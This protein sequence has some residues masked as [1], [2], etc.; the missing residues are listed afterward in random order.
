MIFK[1]VGQRVRKFMLVLSVSVGLAAMLLVGCG[2]T[3][4][5]SNRDRSLDQIQLIE[6]DKGKLVAVIDDFHIYKLIDGE[7]TCYFA[8]EPA[9]ATPT[10][11]CLR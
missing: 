4:R 2:S 1:V 3:V 8:F 9:H 10:I 5:S 6:A 7:T 11:A